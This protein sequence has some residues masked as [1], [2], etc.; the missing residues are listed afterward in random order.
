[1]SSKTIFQMS[2]A[3][4]RAECERRAIDGT[5]TKDDLVV[6]LEQRLRDDGLNPR[7]SL[8]PA[9]QASLGITSDMYIDNNVP[10]DLVGDVVQRMGEMLCN[11]R[12]S[13]V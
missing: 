7:A 13:S 12:P 5:G 11:V 9:G 8:F 6:I 3:E 10:A 1:M 4:L 2:L